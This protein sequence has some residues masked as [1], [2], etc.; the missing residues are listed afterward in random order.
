MFNKAINNFKSWPV[1]VRMGTGGLA[2]LLL[3]VSI[4]MI[5]T[6]FELNHLERY[7]LYVIGR[8]VDKKGEG[9]HRRYMVAYYYKHKRYEGESSADS[10]NPHPIGSLVFVKLDSLRPEF[11]RAMLQEYVPHCL[12]DAKYMDST[13]RG[14]PYCER[15]AEIY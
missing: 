13:W 11:F 12:K 3:G 6:F 15:D 7:R 4:H 5:F 1:G 9:K 14:L 2:I 10:F 8:I